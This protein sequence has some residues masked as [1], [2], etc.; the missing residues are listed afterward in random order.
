MDAVFEE[1]ARE[2]VNF[3]PGDEE[4]RNLLRQRAETHI[5]SLMLIVAAEMAP[6]LRAPL[7]R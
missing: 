3:G 7:Q 4:V 6:T 1:I 5:S 2:T